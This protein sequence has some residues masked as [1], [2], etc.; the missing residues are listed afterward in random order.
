MVQLRSSPG[1][2]PVGPLPAEFLA[3]Y[4]TERKHPLV[5]RCRTVR[6]GSRA[7]LIR[8]VDGEHVGVGLLVLRPEVRAGRVVTKAAWLD[9]EHVDGRFA[10]DDPF[11][12]LPA[13]AAGGGDAEAVAFVQ[14]EVAL[15]PRRPDHRA[16]VRRIGDGA[17]V[18]ILD[19]QFRECGHAAD[20]RFDLRGKPL[21][22]GVEQFVLAVA[23]RAVW[24]TGRRAL[25]VRSEQ[26]AAGF[27][28]HV[29]GTVGLPKHAHFR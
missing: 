22:V 11:G 10:F 14:P 5:T 19:A 2:K 7:F 8:I 20:G 16:A 23:G 15:V 24:I 25:L 28:A 29:P 3:E 1:C 12:E 21:E 27:L 6:A 13:G 17:V 18:D 9:T 4:R 26:Q